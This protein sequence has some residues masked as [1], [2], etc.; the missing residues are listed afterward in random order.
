MKLGKIKGLAVRTGVFHRHLL[1]GNIHTQFAT[2]NI[3][4]TFSI[5]LIQASLKTSG[6]TKY[7]FCYKAL[8]IGTIGNRATAKDLPTMP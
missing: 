3:R 5:Q 8:N 6:V 2:Q 7:L 1:K 4:I